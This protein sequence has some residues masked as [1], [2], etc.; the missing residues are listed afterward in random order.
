MI[1]KL[2]RAIEVMQVFV[3]GGTVMGYEMV[4][5]RFL[6]PYFGSGINTW[7]LLISTVLLALAAGYFCGGLAVRKANPSL[8]SA[9]AATVAGLYLIGLSF[10]ANASLETI[11]ATLG[12][13]FVGLLVGSLIIALVPV[14]L[15]GSMT[16]A[17]VT[18]FARDLGNVGLVSGWVY[19]LSALGNVCGILATTFL[20]IPQWGS[21]A[22]TFGFGLTLV[23]SGVLFWICRP[24]A[25]ENRGS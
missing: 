10:A 5:S 7:A 25:I 14:A 17:F 22:I 12:D 4:A 20:F 6:Y 3:V 13:G 19:A 9:F 8:L 15:L 16:P 1:R 23:A 24:S 11:S 21:R 2:V 18:M